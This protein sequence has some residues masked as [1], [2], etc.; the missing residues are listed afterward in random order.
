[1]WLANHWRGIVVEG[2]FN[3][4]KIFSKAEG[5]ISPY[6]EPPKA[7]REVQGYFNCCTSREFFCS[8]ETTGILKDN[9]TK[10]VGISLILCLKLAMTLTVTHLYIQGLYLE[11]LLD[12]ESQISDR[13]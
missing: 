13:Q 1:M 4:E 5:L 2:Q 10:Q 9:L 11:D 7:D 8:R 3:M 6:L 12:L